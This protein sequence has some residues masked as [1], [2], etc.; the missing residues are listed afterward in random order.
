MATPRLR[1]LEPARLFCPWNYPGRNTGV[2]CH[3]LLQ[4]IFPTQGLN[5]GLLHCRRFF[6]FI[7]SFLWERGRT[8]PDSHPRHASPP[9]P[10]TSVPARG[11]GEEGA[12]P[13]GREAPS[14]APP[15]SPSLLD[16]HSAPHPAPWRTA[17]HRPPG[18]GR[19]RGGKTARVARTTATPRP[20]GRQP[21]RQ[22]LVSKADFQ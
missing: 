18:R 2:G 13:R 7:F 10:P 16:P 14:G 3:S 21:E 19:A 15:S 4:G 6:F 1:G 11:Q 22:T 8:P 9:P 17:A 12:A 20:T 5:P